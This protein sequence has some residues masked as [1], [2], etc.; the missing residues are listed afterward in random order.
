MDSVSKLISETVLKT[1]IHFGCTKEKRTEK[2]SVLFCCVCLPNTSKSCYL[3]EFVSVTQI[4]SIVAV[5]LGNLIQLIRIR[6]IWKLSFGNGS[7][8]NL[9]HWSQGTPS[10][11]PITIKWPS[12]YEDEQ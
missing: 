4:S 5:I 3:L 9:Q 1:E 12:N 11:Y 7:K 10:W 8:K 2:E 6:R